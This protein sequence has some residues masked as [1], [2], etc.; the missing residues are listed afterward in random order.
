LKPPF[1]PT[2][3]ERFE[4]VKIPYE[5][6]RFPPKPPSPEQ[7]MKALTRGDTHKPLPQRK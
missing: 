4:M 7:V 2:I 1:N 3:S 6:P 5:G